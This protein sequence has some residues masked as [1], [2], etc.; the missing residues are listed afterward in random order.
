MD[1]CGHD[2]IV[3]TRAVPR[4]IYTDPEIASVGLTETRAKHGDDVRV[5]KFPWLANAWAVTQNETGGWYKSIP[6]TR[7]GELLGPSWS[8]RT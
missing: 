8:G 4:P 7:Y 6:E 1:A 5:G 3:D 2:E